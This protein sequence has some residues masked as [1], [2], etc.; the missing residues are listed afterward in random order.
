MTTTIVP[1]P[2]TDGLPPTPVLLA[3][4]RQAR[5]DLAAAIA[6]S[7]AARTTGGDR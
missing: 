6:R 3:Q 2:Q 4:S 1:H 5:V 7:E